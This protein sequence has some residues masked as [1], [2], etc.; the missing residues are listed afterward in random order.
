MRRAQ[1]GEQAIAG[2]G[3]VGEAPKLTNH[4]ESLLARASTTSSGNAVLRTPSAHEAIFR[5]HLFGGSGA[6][7]SQD[8][9]F[10][11]R[12]N[13]QSPLLSRCRIRNIFP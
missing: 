7:W 10:M 12:D 1:L 2:I 13:F 5:A 8:A 6:G 11:I 3:G 9:S 4:R